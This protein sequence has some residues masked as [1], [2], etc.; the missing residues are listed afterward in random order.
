MPGLPMIQKLQQFPFILKVT[1]SDVVEEANVEGEIL[2]TSVISVPETFRKAVLISCKPDSVLP[3]VAVSTNK[4]VLIDPQGWEVGDAELTLVLTCFGK[5]AVNCVYESDD[6]HYYDHTFLLRHLKPK[7]VTRENLM[8]AVD[9]RLAKAVLKLGL[10][11]PS[12]K[13]SSEILQDCIT[14]NLIPTEEDTKLVQTRRDCSWFHMLKKAYPPSSH[15]FEFDMY[16]KEME[17]ERAALWRKLK[18][19]CRDLKTQIPVPTKSFEDRFRELQIVQT[20]VTGVETQNPFEELAQHS[21]S[22]ASLR[23]SASNKS[24][25]GNIHKPTSSV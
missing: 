23:S 2:A 7:H 11:F 22:G 9:P 19:I 21:V 1:R 24:A 16:E 3:M 10:F 13:T 20:G 17:M 18:Q 6:T 5:G 8:P 12:E 14:S 15:S 4:H 25:N